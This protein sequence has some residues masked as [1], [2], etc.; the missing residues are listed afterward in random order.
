M[1]FKAKLFTCPLLSLN[2]HYCK[3]LLSV[4]CYS[5]YF[6][7]KVPAEAIMGSKNESTR[8]E[9]GSVEEVRMLL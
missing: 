6:F 5:S 4:L 1:A 2:Y 7:Q 8:T 9:F 3:T